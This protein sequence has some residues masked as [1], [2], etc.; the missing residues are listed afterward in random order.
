MTLITKDVLNGLK[1]KEKVTVSGLQR[2]HSMGFEKAHDLFDELVS[3]GYITQDGVVQRTMILKEL[4]EPP[5]EE[6]KLIFLDI[7]GVLNSVSTKELC[8]DYKGIDHK[9]MGVLRHIIVAT[10]AK[11]VLTSSWKEH[12]YKEQVLKKFQDESANYL[13]SGFKEYSLTVFDKTEDEGFNRGDGIREYLR[14]LKWKG[15]EVGKFVIIDDELFDYKERKLTKNLVQTSYY[16]GG[17]K[18]KHVDK[19]IEVL[20]C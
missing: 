6:M 13:D 14:H 1:D 7:D 8:G 18:E 19:T 10:G 4:G 17:L 15:I 9:N 11:I 16:G 5:K 20:G 12:C 2:D 3:N